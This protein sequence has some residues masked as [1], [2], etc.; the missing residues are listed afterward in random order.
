MPSP[1]LSI[2]IIKRAR[3]LLR[4]GKISH[5]DPSWS[6][7]KAACGRGGWPMAIFFTASPTSRQ[8]IIAK[9]YVIIAKDFV[10]GFLYTVSLPLLS[11]LWIRGGIDDPL[12]AACTASCPASRTRG[13]AAGIE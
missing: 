7:T 1:A 4:C 10:L 12:R 13:S 9:E 2:A 3:K 5:A 8:L 6:G 11:T